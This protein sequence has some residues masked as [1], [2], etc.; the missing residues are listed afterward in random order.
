[1]AV[2]RKCEN[3]AAGAAEGGLRFNLLKGAED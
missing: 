2:I 1:M 3:T